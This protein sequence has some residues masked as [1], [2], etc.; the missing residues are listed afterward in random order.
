LETKTHNPGGERQVASLYREF[1][2]AVYRR[3]LRL[4]GDRAAA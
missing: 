4:L 2:P 1:G 3:C